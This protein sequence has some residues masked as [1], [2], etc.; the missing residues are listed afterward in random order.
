[1]K[2]TRRVF[3][4][5]SATAL[6]ASLLFSRIAFAADSKP[7]LGVQLYSVRDDMA[8]DALGS[9]KKVAAMG[10]KYVEHASYTNR[11]F[12]GYTAQE[13]K[14]ILSD[15]GLSMPS[16][17]T[18]LTKQH[19]NETAK[20]FTDGWKYTIEDAATAGQ[21]Y[22]I[23][24]WLDQTL[25][26]TASDLTRYMDVFNKCGELCKSQGL[27]FGYHNHDFE[28][29]TK[30]GDETVY[31]II[32]KNTDPSLVIQQLDIGNMYNGHAQAS[33]IIKKYPGR[34][35]SLH[36]KDE[37]KSSTGKENH[38]STILGKGVIGVK[39][40]LELALKV[41]GANHLIVE[42]EAYQ[43]MTPMDCIAA[44]FKQMKDWGY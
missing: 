11:K 22:V 1:M 5:Q 17:H 15:L 3:V 35:L 33:D 25:R 40:V 29:N 31:D 16:G 13:F 27:Q 6:S 19:W 32:L 9:L 42:Q 24:P 26:T 30:F 4:R 14:T 18:V 7:I 28:F 43:G 41:G 44:D 10:Y 2:I 23:S 34:F 36:V 39:S 38:E 8:K 21:Q 37:I 20:D 12:Y